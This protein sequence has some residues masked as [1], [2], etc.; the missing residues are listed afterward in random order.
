MGSI[1]KPLADARGCERSHDREG[2]VHNRMRHTTR[3][4]TQV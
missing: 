1:G 2:V 3:S 4:E